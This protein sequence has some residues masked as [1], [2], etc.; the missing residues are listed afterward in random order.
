MDDIMNT[1]SLQH[2]IMKAAETQQCLFWITQL[3]SY[4]DFFS[5][6]NILY[7]YAYGPLTNFGLSVPLVT[8]K[9]STEL[10]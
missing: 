3:Y 2:N 1:N 6:V 5:P 10:Q 8:P 7:V 4:F 9:Y